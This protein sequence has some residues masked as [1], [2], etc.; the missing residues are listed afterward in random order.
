MHRSG[1]RPGTQRL[2]LIWVARNLRQFAPLQDCKECK[3]SGC[4]HCDQGKLI[5]VREDYAYRYQEIIRCLFPD[6]FNAHF[7]RVEVPNEP[8]GKLIHRIE[9]CQQEVL[10]TRNLTFC[11]GH[12]Q[13]H[14][15]MLTP[16]KN[17]EKARRE[18]D[19]PLKDHELGWND[20][21]TR[22]LERLERTLT[23]DSS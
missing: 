21:V 3:G 12:G 4:K 15:Q 17:I 10:E 16:Q 22:L 20:W 14:G 13:N 9:Y 6:E 7:V 19:R 1:V 5:Y 8:Y 23:T 11:T 2:H 18:D